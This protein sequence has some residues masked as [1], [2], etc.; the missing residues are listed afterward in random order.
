MYMLV[1]GVTPSGG[2]AWLALLR[3]VWVLAPCC[4]LPRSASAPL[5]YA[6]TLV[7]C[8]FQVASVKPRW[9][10]QSCIRLCMANRFAVAALTSACCGDASVVGSHLLVFH[11]LVNG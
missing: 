9:Y 10:D 3:V 8:R 2:E 11:W 6:E 5:P 7:F 4:A 1:T